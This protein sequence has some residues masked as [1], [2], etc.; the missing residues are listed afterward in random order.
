[1]HMIRWTK[2]AAGLLGW[3]LLAAC[4]GSDAARVQPPANP[5]PEPA[6]VLPEPATSAA[7]PPVVPPAGTVAAA[8]D[9]AAPAE[10]IAAPL[11]LKLQGPDPVP[12]SGD[13]A[14]GLDI[15]TREAIN[16]P[17]TLKVT[18]PPGATL[19][20]GKAEEVLQISQAGTIRRDFVV[21]TTSTLSAPVVITAD[22]RDPNGNAGMHA[23]RKYPDLSKLVPP[24]ATVPQPPAGRPPAPPPGGRPPA[25]PKK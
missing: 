12:S 15:V 10:R 18:L 3:S 21:R 13:I 7:Q 22:T 6:P 9:T 2:M 23:E 17:V 25:A 8:A 20:S 1:M 14:L 24:S 16:G 11:V 4:G 5:A 19:A